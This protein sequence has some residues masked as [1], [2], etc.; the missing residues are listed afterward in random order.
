[1]SHKPRLIKVIK[2]AHSEFTKAD[3]IAKETA[4]TGKVTV[5]VVAMSIFKR[6]RCKLRSAN[7]GNEKH[8]CQK[9]ERANF[10]EGNTRGSRNLSQKSRK[11]QLPKKLASTLKKLELNWTT[12]MLKS[13]KYTLRSCRS[14]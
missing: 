12:L 4:K 8:S 6:K 11:S 9:A 2:T 1:L 7:L 14:A 5:V 13:K 3:E 10:P